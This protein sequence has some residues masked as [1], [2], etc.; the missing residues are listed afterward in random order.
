[1]VPV[2]PV[3]GLPLPAE[4]LVGRASILEDL[5]RRVLQGQSVLIP[6]PRRVGKSPTHV[7]V[8]RL[9]HPGDLPVRRR[10]HARGGEPAANTTWS[11]PAVPSPRT[12]G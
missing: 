3:D 5:E 10:P 6:G 8:N 11:P 2:F 7:G 4:D 9:V 1:M 12:W